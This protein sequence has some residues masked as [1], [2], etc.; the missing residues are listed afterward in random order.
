MATVRSDVSRAV[1]VSGL[2]QLARTV[3]KENTCRWAVTFCASKDMKRIGMVDGTSV[4]LVV[5]VVVVAVSKAQVLLIVL[6]LRL[7]TSRS[8][9]PERRL[10]CRYWW[11]W[12]CWQCRRH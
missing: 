3:P 8:R 6:L 2:C 10:C 7:G 12:G 5:V 9:C 1:Q 11:W 4:E